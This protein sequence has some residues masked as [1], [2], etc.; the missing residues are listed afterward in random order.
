M[1]DGFAGFVALLISWLVIFALGVAFGNSEQFT[2]E[3]ALTRAIAEC[4]THQGIETMELGAVI[5]VTCKDKT[6]IEFNAP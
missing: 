1:D 5:E 4:R 2:S 3:A 6:S